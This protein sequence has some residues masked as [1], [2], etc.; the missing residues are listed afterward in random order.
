MD[1][2]FVTS[3][4]EV[5]RVDG[6]YILEIDPPGFIQGVGSSVVGVV[7]E[8]EQGPLDEVIT[9]G[10]S[11]EFT[12]IFGGYGKA[13][14]GSESTWRGYSG[15][16]AL[17][18]KA[19]PAGI[20]VVRVART[21]MAKATGTLKLPSAGGYRVLT[22]TAKWMGRYGNGLI[23]NVSVAS[24]SSLAD[25]FR[26][27]VSYGDKSDTID[28]LYPTMPFA[29]LQARLQNTVLVDAAIGAQTVGA[30]DA[31]P[32]TVAMTGGTDGTTDVLNNWTSGIDKLLGQRDLNILF[33]AELP[34]TP[35]TYPAVNSYIKGKLVPTSS[36]AQFVMAIVCGP[37]GDSIDAAA[38]AATALR[39]DRMVYTFP[40]RKQVYPEAAPIT[41]DGILAVP[42]SDAIACALANIDPVYDPA[43]KFGARFVNACT[44]GLEF[45]TLTRETYVTANQ[46][47][48][49][50]LE[51][52]PD[53][54]YR[55]VSGVTTDLTPAKEM[56]HRRRLSDYLTR[57]VAFFLKYY[58]NQPITQDWKDDVYGAVY[59]YLTQQVEL[60]PTPRVLGFD[61]DTV[62]VNSPQTEAQGLWKILMKVRTPASARFIV[63]MAQV[64]PTVEVKQV[65]DLTAA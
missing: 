51:F 52:D 55:P 39:T 12:R 59:D 26:L 34:G 8:F 21:G 60:K 3:L 56:I 20:R 46:Q 61:L 33:Y 65:D 45:Q 18:G 17:A 41:P 49:C 25:G 40:W 42:S 57:S 15:Y 13:E 28:N 9:V 16:R 14:P 31:I 1:P 5:T 50:A 63:L 2:R 36:A 7:G 44:A 11:S 10:S 24:D 29:D 23:A 35:V 37:A 62:S 58:Q 47:G 27:T 64:G 32:A 22:L 19:W 30:P 43:S 54:G 4:T 53:L 38:T 48:V 6:V